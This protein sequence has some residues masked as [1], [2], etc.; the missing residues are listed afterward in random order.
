MKNKLTILIYLVSLIFIFS[1][2]FI[3]KD[4]I[5][6]DDNRLSL[7]DFFNDIVFDRTIKYINESEKIYSKNEIKNLLIPFLNI[8]YDDYTLNFE[9]EYITIKKET[10]I[11]PSEHFDFKPFLI[12]FVEK[13]Y[14]NIS[15]VEFENLPYIEDVTDVEIV[16]SFINNSNLF[17]SLRYKSN[18][19]SKFS[20]V[21]IIVEKLEK[22]LLTKNQILRGDVIAK[23][24]TYEATINILDYNFE[25]I[26]IEDIVLGKYESTKTFDKDEPL[27]KTYLKIIPDIIKG[28]VV[29]IFVQIGGIHIQTIGKAL[30]NATYGQNITVKNIETNK[31]VTGILREGPSVY[32]NLGGE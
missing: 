1:N 2:T 31:T 29:N 7:K 20:S 9:S 12:D 17:I 6:T 22:V 10:K 14:P 23:E 19:I 4:I 16:N 27:N 24:N 32:V 3:I 26:N 11:N 25:T 13:Q 28:D 8:Y 21:K 15:I 18:N 30:K 5:I